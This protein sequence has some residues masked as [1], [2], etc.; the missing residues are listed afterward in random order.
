[1]PDAPTS[2]TAMQFADY[3]LENYIAVDSKFP[4]IF[5]HK[6]PDLFPLYKQWRWVLSQPSECGILCKAS[7]HLRVCW[8]T[9]K[10]STNSVAT[11]SMSQQA[12]QSKHQ[13]EKTEFVMSAYYDY[14][15]QLIIYKKGVFEESVSSLWTENRTVTMHVVLI[16]FYLDPSHAFLYSFF[17]RFYTLLSCVFIHC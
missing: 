1:M 5:W 2:D 15:T 9:E 10:D 17:M 16:L 14:R 7:K 3:V 12:R 4:P 11:N 6:P 8:C 13:R